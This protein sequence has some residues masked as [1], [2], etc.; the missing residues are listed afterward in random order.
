[1]L[2]LLVGTLVL[3]THYSLAKPN[4]IEAIK[5]L[6]TRLY[7]CEKK[8]KDPEVVRWCLNN[9]GKV[10]LSMGNTQSAIA[11]FKPALKLAEGTGNL[12]SEGTAIGNL[13]SALREAG[14]YEEA[15]KC[16]KEYL[17]NTGKRLDPGGE[18]IMLYELA[19]DHIYMGDLNEA[20]GFALKG[21]MTLQRIHAALS[22]QDNQAKLETLRRIK[23]GCSIS[24]CMFSQ[25]W[26]KMRLHYLHQNLVMHERLLTQCKEARTVS[27]SLLLTS[28][29]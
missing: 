13:G 14:R 7:L 26:G 1:M 22:S 8:L 5:Y 4:H 23:Q 25:S 9:I 29:D 27:L 3:Y 19:V 18:A 15:V 6:G 17:N 11:C 28:P 24:Y 20:K 21:V 12:L 2:H 10:Y 16:H